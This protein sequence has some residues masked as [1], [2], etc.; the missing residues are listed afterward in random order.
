MA[1]KA[2]IVVFDITATGD[3]IADKFTFPVD[4]I[5][6]N[7]FSLSMNHHKD[8]Y[9]RT[10]E[11]IALGDPLAFAGFS[12]FDRN[13]Y[14]LTPGLSSLTRSDILRTLHAEGGRQYG[15]GVHGMTFI[16]DDGFSDSTAYFST[17]AYGVDSFSMFDQAD[18]MV[19]TDAKVFKTSLAYCDVGEGSFPCL[20][21]GCFTEEERC[22]GPWNCRDGTDEG[23]CNPVEALYQEML[24]FRRSR[25]NHLDRHYAF[26][27]CWTDGNISPEGHLIV[28]VTCRS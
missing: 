26:A 21:G 20:S 1:P 18:L 25:F 13:L 12:A 23:Q 8:Y 2:H 10:F 17:N 16:S 24:E 3:V 5:S 6:R 9:K 7:K 11:I 28:T 15:S 4:G 27:C 14:P 22:D 19:F